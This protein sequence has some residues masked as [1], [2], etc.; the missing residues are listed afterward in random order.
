MRSDNC[1]YCAQRIISLH[2]GIEWDDWRTVDSVR[3]SMI[4]EELPY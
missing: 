4:I 3:P 1:V 2:T